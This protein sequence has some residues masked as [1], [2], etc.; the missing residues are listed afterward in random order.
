MAQYNIG[1]KR[2]QG[3]GCVNVVTTYTGYQSV[4][5]SGDSDTSNLGFQDAVI[6]P[7][8]E[9]GSFAKGQDYYLKIRIPQDMNYEMT[10]NIKL[11]P[12]SDGSADTKKYQFVKRISINRGGTGTNVY[13]VVLYE[14][15]N[16][17]IAV[18]FPLA[19]DINKKSQ[20]DKIYTNK[21]HTKYYLG[22][23]NGEYV[24]TD[25]FNDIA[26]TASWRQENSSDTY[27]VFEMVFRPVSNDFSRLLLEM[28][29]TAEDYN[30]QR[31]VKDEEN[32]TEFTEY[33]RKIAITPND[34]VLYKLVNQIP[35]AQQKQG[36]SRIG[37]WGH[38]G[39]MMAING[40]E[41][42]IGPSGHY[43][44]DVISIKSLG[45]VAEN[46][47]WADD[48]TLD[49]EYITTAEAEEEEGV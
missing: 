47:N 13:N 12:S 17:E 15:S 21:N 24:S 41:I 48:W 22:G 25:K 32:N 38:P 4:S 6:F 8:E 37:I 5:M 40:E 29:R 44:Q 27:G 2:F 9:E 30:I 26:L 1:Q 20:Q 10:F 16:E 28:E 31:L 45:I 49:Y 36:L 14:K 11:M 23:S 34:V 46:D 33:G 42:R 43:E 39:L 35:G 3:N 18:D 7:T 19:Y